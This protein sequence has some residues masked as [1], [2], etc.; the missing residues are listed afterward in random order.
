MLLTVI[1]AW[2]ICAVVTAII[3]GSR[4][5]NPIAWLAI[6]AVIGIFGLI[7]V[8]ALPAARPASA[9]GSYHPMI[10]AG[11]KIDPSVKDCPDCRETVSISAWKCPH[12]GFRLA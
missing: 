9:S 5:R 3:A 6:G 12:C 11:R 2:A 1:F 4:D 10:G 8:L 7:L